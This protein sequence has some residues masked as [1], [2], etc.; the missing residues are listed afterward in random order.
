VLSR[1]L[2]GLHRPI[3]RL[4]LRSIVGLTGH[5]I[6]I[7]GAERLRGLPDPVIFAFNH[8][9]A[10]ESIA[11]PS[12]LIFARGG[13]RIQFLVDWMY[14]KT[15]LVGWILRQIDPIPIYNKRARWGLWERYRQ[16]RRGGD[17]IEACRLRLR[18]GHSVGIFPEGTRNGDPSTLR[19]GRKGL[20]RLVLRS[21][22]PV[23]PVGIDFPARHRLGRMPRVGRILVHVGTPLHFLPERARWT[24]A[25][26]PRLERQLSATIV[27]SVMGALEALSAKT[28]PYT[29]T[30]RHGQSPL[31][32][33]RQP[34]RSHETRDHHQQGSV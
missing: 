18:Q 30:H 32:A 6:Q 29:N 5:W 24:Q 27:D 8:N 34:G 3:H 7:H 31:G 22:V 17:P 16:A 20:G 15:P 23:L 11:V 21:Q 33:P 4:V 28:Y 2:P 26:D 13:H 10:Y 14:L 12:A 19:R 9:N 25:P 1:P